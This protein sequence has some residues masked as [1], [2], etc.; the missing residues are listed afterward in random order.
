MI[1]LEF[2]ELEGISSIVCGSFAELTDRIRQDPACVIVADSWTSS[3][4]KELSPEERE[5]ICN[6]DQM[7]AGVILT[8]A[9][10]WARQGDPGFSSGVVVLPKP[11]DLDALGQVIHQAW[12]RGETASPI[13]PEK[14][15]RSGA[16]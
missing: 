11:Y 13:A 15:Q 16:T 12:A 2:F 1:L 7:A 6:L 10:A 3:I 8:T 5:Q 9:R 14:H 4:V